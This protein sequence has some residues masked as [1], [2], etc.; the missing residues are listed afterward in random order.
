VQGW[1]LLI[2]KPYDLHDFQ[3]VQGASCILRPQD[4]HVLQDV[5]YAGPELL[6]G[7]WSSFSAANQPYSAI[8]D[9][10]SQV[11]VVRDAVP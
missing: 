10:W 2:T 1:A 7:T 6:T 11:T 9:Q 5:P 8:M 4:P 3:Y